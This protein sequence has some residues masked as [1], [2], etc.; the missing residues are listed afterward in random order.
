MVRKTDTHYSSSK[1]PFLSLPSLSSP[2]AFLLAGAAASSC[3]FDDGSTAVA[4]RLP[5][6]FCRSQRR[7]DLGN[8]VIWIVSLGG[9]MASG[10]SLS[11][12]QCHLQI[13]RSRPLLLDTRVWSKAAVCKTKSRSKDI[14]MSS[15]VTNSRHPASWHS[16]VLA[17]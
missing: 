4:V 17:H 15:L 10:Q 8:L 11:I 1:S 5:R 13:G 14:S 2:F 12:G 6:R 3:V 7:T 16:R 9:L